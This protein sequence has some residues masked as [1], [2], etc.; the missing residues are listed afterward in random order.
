[1]P[2]R[3][4]GTPRRPQRPPELVITPTG[5]SLEAGEVVRFSV[6]LAAE[7]GPPEPLSAQWSCSDG[8][9]LQVG[10]DGVVTALRPGV[11][12]LSASA[13]GLEST[14][15]LQVT[16]VGVARLILTPVRHSLTVAEQIQLRVAAQDG[17]GTRLGGRVVTWS[18]DHP[19]VA[20][21]SRTGVVEALSPGVV[22]ISASSGAAGAVA[23]VRVGP[24]VVSSVRVNPAS[25]TLSPGESYHFHAVPLNG[26]GRIIPGLEISWVTS[27]EMVAEVDEHGTVTGHRGGV[28]R[29]AAVAGG[30]RTTIAVTVLPRRRSRP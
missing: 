17:F 26:Q 3:P 16:R 2:V 6:A 12:V 30:R 9:V 24:P 4:S 15:S 23:V 25:A 28:A 7:A 20:T 21:V 1:M 10:E 8:A 13:A 11:A 18:S 22:E 19:E 14:V 29:L 27:D 5:G